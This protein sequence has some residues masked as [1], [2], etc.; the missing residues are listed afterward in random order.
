[1]APVINEYYPGLEKVPWIKLG[2]FPS[3]VERLEEMGRAHGFTELYIKRDDCCHTVYGGNKVRKLEYV[4]ADAK[5]KNRR[6]LITVGATGSNQVLATGIHGG[7]QGFRVMGLMF[8]QPNAEYLRR[9][10]LLDCH[11]G[12]E[13]KYTGSLVGEIFLLCSEYL[14][15]L[16]RGDKPYYVPGG[17]SSPV[18]NLGFVNAVYELNRQVEEGLVPE[19]DYIVAAAGS[20]GTTAGL[21]LGCRLLKL[22]TRVLAV[23]VGLPWMVNPRGYANMVRSICSYMRK[24]DPGVPEIRCTE[25]DVTMLTDYLGGGYAHLTELGF[26]TVL[27]MGELEGIPMDPT[28]TGKALGGGLD[29]LKK[30]G[31][32]DKVVLFWDTYNSVDLS[33]LCADVDYRALP[34][35]FHKYFTEPTQEELMAEG[36][37]PASPD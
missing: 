30:N 22:K 9:N 13:V 7:G 29:W 5:S 20:L 15:A 14:K 23:R 24:H 36:S 31:E 21:E 2:N 33:G 26:N 19:P 3:R 1:M 11:Y 25:N 32:Q 34:R 37:P 16:M 18:G 4:L 27:D 17:A 12:V 8:H 10:L 6:L 35:G 28:Y